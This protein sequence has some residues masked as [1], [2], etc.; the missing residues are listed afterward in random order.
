MEGPFE[1]KRKRRVA[2]RWKHYYGFLIAS[3]ML[4][5]F[6]QDKNKK[7]DFKKAVDFR[8]N[9]VTVSKDDRLRL[10]VYAQGRNWLLKFAM[11]KE[12]SDW[13]DAIKQFS[14]CPVKNLS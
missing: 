2:Y 7:I 13:H 8:E 6:G 3:G 11:Q 9:S 10:D 1:K 5:Y 4:L 12:I 14:R